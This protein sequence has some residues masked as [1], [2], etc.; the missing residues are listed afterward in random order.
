MLQDPGS[1]VV[2]MAHQIVALVIVGN[3]SAELGVFD[4]RFFDPGTPLHE[5]YKFMVI[6]SLPRAQG[7][8][9]QTVQGLGS[10]YL[11]MHFEPLQHAQKRRFGG[12]GDIAKNSVIQISV[13]GFQDLGDQQFS[14]L[15]AFA[16]DQRVVSS[17][18]VNPLKGASRQR[19]FLKNPVQSIRPI[20]PD[21]QGM[22]RGDFL[23]LVRGYAQGRGHRRSF[24]RGNHHLVV[25][26]PVRG[27]NPMRISQNKGITMAQKTGHGKTPIPIPGRFAQ[28]PNQ[29]QL[30]AHLRLQRRTVR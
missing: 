4:S 14:E 18:K 6:I 9:I 13:N 22:A 3:K 25:G 30:T 21:N 26:K 12:V 19:S 15:F 5:A 28:N 2:Y 11:E 8:G 10:G 24:G 1:R 17:R 23:N 27:P 16:V 29:V 20:C 7:F